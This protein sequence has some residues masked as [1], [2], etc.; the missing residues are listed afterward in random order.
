MFKDMN[1]PQELLEDHALIQ[2]KYPYTHLE[3]YTLCKTLLPH[4]KSEETMVEKYL[5]SK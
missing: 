5:A 3:K 1:F 2:P 4:L